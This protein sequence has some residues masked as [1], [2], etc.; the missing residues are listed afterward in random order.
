MVTTLKDLDSGMAQTV[1]PAA[2]QGAA[3]GWQGLKQS[4]QPHKARQGN[5]TQ[6][7]MSSIVKDMS[8]HGEESMEHDGRVSIPP[9]PVVSQ[10]GNVMPSKIPDHA[11]AE[12]VTCR[13]RSAKHC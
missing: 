13:D 11:R 9:A 1:T 3:K 8:I 12:T 7:R 10:D 6:H 2:A 4:H 5:M